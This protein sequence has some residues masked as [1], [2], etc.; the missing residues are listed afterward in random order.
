[1]D[2]FQRLLLVP[3]RG[4][5]FASSAALPGLGGGDA[6][7]GDGGDGGAGGEGGGDAGDD[8]GADDEG[9]GGEEGE[10]EGEGGEEA[11]GEGEQA[12][13][14]EGEGEEGDQG[15]NRGKKP[16]VESAI[17]KLRKTDPAMAD[18]LRREHF[19]NKQFR[20][21][22]SVQEVEAMRDFIQLHEGVE[23]IEFRMEQ[24]NKFA[25]EMQMVA[26]GDAKII[27]DLA[28][29][30]PEGLMKLGPAFLDELHRIDAD[31]FGLMMAKPMSRLLREMM[32]TPQMEQLRR[33]I[34]S[35]DQKSAF[36]YTNNFLNWIKELDAQ[37]GKQQEQVAPADKQLQDR[38]QKLTEREQKTYRTDVARAST[39]ST[40]TA[41][42]AFLN[43]IIVA[44]KKRGV[45]L[46]TAQKQDVAKGV[47]DE[48]A[49]S[50]S[51]NKQYKRQM[52][53]FYD[54][55]AD[56]DKIAEYVGNKVRALAKQAVDAVWERKGWAG[57]NGKK[58]GGAGAGGAG[59]GNGAGRAQFVNAVPKPET[60]DWDADPDRKRYQGDGRVGEVTLLGTKRVVRFKW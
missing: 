53:A 10:S 43:P 12:D 47:Y 8:G 58:T 36:D 19:Q 52:D 18:V 34:Q 23:E 31:R 11:E 28:G 7:G 13:E 59:G 16:D 2:I 30:S 26:N 29:E 6:G 33:F 1:M 54:R 48:I 45:I 46:S 35:G 38:A 37:A 57:R 25:A 51:A 42:G 27:K 5:F 44:A 39:T 15:K 4:L 55:N 22:G 60:I 3:F 14:G 21:V 24:G 9:A 56:P 17:N 40:N 32:F 50:L 49:A 20:E 41:I